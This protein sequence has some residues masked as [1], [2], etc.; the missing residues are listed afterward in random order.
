MKRTVS[1]LLALLMLAGLLAGCG[2]GGEETVSTEP[3]TASSAP[4]G[5][6]TE[7]SAAPTAAPSD[8]AEPTEIELPLV[9]ESVTFEY[10]LPNNAT[11]EDFASYAD[12]EFY[13]W[14]E[15][16]TGVHIEF[17]H[18]ATGSEKESFQ[19]MVLSQDYPDFVQSVKTY[20]DGGV[21]KAIADGFLVRL[22]EKV[23]ELMPN[24]RAQVYR[25][26]DTIIGSFSDEGNLWGIHQ[27]YEAEKGA[28]LGL[29]IRQDWLDK[30][31][32][33]LAD[34]ETIDGLESVLTK[35][36]DYTYNNEG[37]LFLS[38]GGMQ[39]GCGLNGSYNVSS[40]IWCASGMINKDGVAVYSPTEPGFKEYAAKMADW[41][42]KGLINKNYVVD[43]AYN[44]PQDRWANSEAGVGE[45]VYTQ[46]PTFAAAAAASELMP[47]PDFKL[48]AMAT[49][50]LNPGD[51]LKTD[52]HIRQCFE[53]VRPGNSMGITTG[54]DDLD[55]ACR[56]WDYAWIDEGKVRANWGSIGEYGDT[57]TTSYIGETDTTGDG[58]LECFQPWLMEKYNNITNVQT[59]YCVHNGPTYMIGTREWCA[60]S[61]EEIGF[62][63]EWEKAG[64]DWMWPDSV[65]L[66]KD[67]GAH[68]S[69]ILTACN[70]SVNEWLA[71]VITGEKSVDTYDTELLPKLESVGY[72][73]AVADYQAA[74]DRMFERSKFTE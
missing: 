38:N 61:Q 39:A 9:E 40:V 32:L 27:I 8:S 73:D 69:S 74:L 42:A 67:E 51:D 48:V 54:C 4:A 5:S 41:Y 24:Y 64:H 57:T 1:L 25:D 7:Q 65:T 56:Y 36:V 12:N 60:L 50:K 53:I 2:G 22:N 66:T 18:P 63:F 44:V 52:V 29:G 23:D 19:T 46:G 6:D 59:K 30:A 13:K 47:D 68:S 3:S 37:P 34:V 15:A 43:A 21:D 58:H 55:L 70:T 71:A 17:D 11:F 72:K 14:M 33:T 62:T 45:W 20:Y 28:W 10:W 35:F 26:K 31:G 49:P 16:Q